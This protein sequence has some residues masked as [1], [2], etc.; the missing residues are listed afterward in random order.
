MWATKKSRHPGGRRQLR[1]AM[2]AGAILHFF[3]PAGDGGGVFQDLETVRGH[4]IWDAAVAQKGTA[5]AYRFT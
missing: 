1:D 5:T 3:S 4:R 2:A